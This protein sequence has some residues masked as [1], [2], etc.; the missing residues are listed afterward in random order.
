MPKLAASKVPVESVPAPSGSTVRRFLFVPKAGAGQDVI[1]TFTD[2]E[3]C[4]AVRDASDAADV[5]EILTVLGQPNEQLSWSD[6]PLKWVAESAP[7]IAITIHGAQ[8]IWSTGRA[9]VQAAPDRMEPLLAALID[10]CHHERELRKIETEV[11]ES[12]PALSDDASLAAGVTARDRDRFEEAGLRMEQTL[13]RR[14]RL[15]RIVPHFTRPNPHHTPLANQL[16]ERLREKAHIEERIEA[17][18][19]QFEAFERIC[20]MA[21]QRIAD[22]NAA[23]VSHTLEWIIIVMLAT[24]ALLLLLDI[25]WVKGL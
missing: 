3:P 16:A 4:V 8:V 12:W 21:S 15:A 5:L 10:F 24:E 18:G 20:E 9:A 2:P 13:R 22:F 6:E 14:I 23:R 7:P 11:A 17:L 19:G 1:A 25:L